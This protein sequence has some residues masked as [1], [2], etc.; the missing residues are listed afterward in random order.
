ME[1]EK[2]RNGLTIGEFAT[3]SHLS[4]RTLR[5]YH[6]AGLLEPATVDPFTN[7]RYYNPDQIA[8]AQVIQRLRELDMPLVEV[9][10]ILAAEDPQQRTELLAGHLRRLEAELDRTRAAVVSLRQLL[11]PEADELEVEMRSVPA[12]SVAAISTPAVRLEEAVGWFDT[13]MDELDA[14]FPPAERTGAPG[15]LYTNELFTECVGAMTVFRPV[16][17]PVACGRITILELPSADLAVT[18]HAGRHDDIDVSYG[19]LG[20]WVASHTLVVGGPVHE[21]YLVGPR[22]VD[23]D[24]RWRTEIGWPVFRL[25][26]A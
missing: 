18:V 12:R 5:R 25:T 20:A 13:A 7:Y 26:P 6:E 15:G 17:R 1:T 16:R 14:A 11:R 23:N 10:S 19:R 8:T 21:T 2:M 4:V 24:Q 3:L 9:K 22:D